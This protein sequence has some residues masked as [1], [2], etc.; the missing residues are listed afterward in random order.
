MNEDEYYREKI[1]MEIIVDCYND[2]E[3]SWGW[4]AYMED[5][6]IFPFKAKIIGDSCEIPVGEIVTVT[7]MLEDFEIVGSVWWLKD[8][9]DVINKVEVQ[10]NNEDFY[11]GIDDLKP[12]DK[13]IPTLESIKSWN[14]WLEKY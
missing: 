3:I 6:L 13:D 12:L 4:E 9:A 2:E 14:F 8:Q 11:I 10:W 5:R 7:D 1:D